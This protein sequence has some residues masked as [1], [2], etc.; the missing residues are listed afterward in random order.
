VRQTAQELAKDAFASLSV[1]EVRAHRFSASGCWLDGFVKRQEFP[2]RARHPEWRTSINK[3]DTPCF[4]HRLKTAKQEYPV[5]RIF[6]F[7]QTSWK[8]YLGTNKVLSQ[9]GI[10]TVKLYLRRGGQASVPTNQ[11]K[12]GFVSSE[13]VQGEPILLVLD[14][15]RAHRTSKMQERAQELHTELLFV[16]AGRTSVCQ[17]LDRRVFGQSKARARLAFEELTWRTGVREPTPEE[18]IVILVETWR[19][20]RAQSIRSAWELG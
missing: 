2:L 13:R 17:P 12:D 11:G 7:D 10:E 1:A 4:L 5:Y 16:P 18:A 14:V 8:R 19:A 6:N 9:K 20:I 3:E 15:Y